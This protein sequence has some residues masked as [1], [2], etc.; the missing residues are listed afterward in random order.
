MFELKDSEDENN[1]PAA[2][3]PA[4]KPRV[5]S[6]ML[7][8]FC[9][10]YKNLAGEM[11]DP[12]AVRASLELVLRLQDQSSPELQRA[13]QSLQGRF[14]VYAEAFTGKVNTGSYATLGEAFGAAQG[15]GIFGEPGEIAELKRVVDSVTGNAQLRERMIYGKR[16]TPLGI[17]EVGFLDLREFEYGTRLARSGPPVVYDHGAGAFR[18]GVFQPRGVGV[19][20]KSPRDVRE[21]LLL[22]R[23]FVGVWRRVGKT[24]WQGEFTG[25]THEEL[26]QWLPNRIYSEPSRLIPELEP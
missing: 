8:L 18:D 4:L 20:R 9:E 11:P 2:A 6:E 7:K 10:S 17:E 14:I 1:L 13:A 16:M 25:R 21:T 23:G 15:K 26:D 19:I 24:Y 5:T 12:S 3:A 22:S